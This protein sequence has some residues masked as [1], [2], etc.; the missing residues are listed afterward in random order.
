MLFRSTGRPVD[1]GNE[2]HDQDDEPPE[3]AAIVT[4]TVP[5]LADAVRQ[6]RGYRDALEHA[7]RHLK[8][9]ALDSQRRVRL[10]LEAVTDG[11]VGK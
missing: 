3:A 10:A 5:E 4:G 9:A 8:D 11:L 2:W 6:A 1:C 7:Q